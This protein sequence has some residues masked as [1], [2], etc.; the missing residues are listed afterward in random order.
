MQGLE[1]LNL[2][3]TAFLWAQGSAPLIRIR[4]VDYKMRTWT[5]TWG[6]EMTMAPGHL[7]LKVRAALHHE[8]PPQEDLWIG[9]V[10]PQTDD[11]LSGHQHHFQ[12]LVQGPQRGTPSLVLVH[13][14]TASRPQVRVVPVSTTNPVTC[15]ELTAQ[16]G[17]T[18][19]CHAPG[20]RCQCYL[21]GVAPFGTDRVFLR[22][23]QKIEV[24][25]EVRHQVCEQAAPSTNE[26][27]EEGDTFALFDLGEHETAGSSWA[28]AR[29]VMVD[30]VLFM[31]RLMTTLRRW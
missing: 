26:A 25:V 4:H 24:H 7:A 2:D 17:C 5:T 14:G 29:Q 23:W 9:A 19:L 15:R 13:Y 11:A 18:G 28:Y 12:V 1:R 20:I 21:E 22:G 8:V 3:A 10:V 31:L 30:R 6:D 27:E 16:A